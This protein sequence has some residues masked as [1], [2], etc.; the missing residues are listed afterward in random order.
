MTPRIT[1]SGLLYHLQ[2]TIHSLAASMLYQCLGHFIEDFLI[3]SM[4]ITSDQDM[5]DITRVMNSAW[6]L[7]RVNSAKTAVNWLFK[8]TVWTDGNCY[9]N[10]ETKIQA[11]FRPNSLPEVLRMDPHM[12]TVILML[13]IWKLKSNK[14]SQ[15]ILW[16]YAM[17]LLAY[18]LY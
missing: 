13:D 1:N 12:G 17:I 7:S 18:L 4:C 14:F 11:Q 6:S 9:L 2:F 8:N 16:L 3:T 5:E 15:L 10:A